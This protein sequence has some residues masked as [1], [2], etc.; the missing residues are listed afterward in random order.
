MPGCSPYRSS[1]DVWLTRRRAELTLARDAIA[2]A[3]PGLARAE[4]AS[5]T[6][7]LSG[8][9]GIAGVPVVAALTVTGRLAEATYAFLGALGVAL[10]LA[11]LGGLVGRLRERE[12]HAL[13]PL[14]APSGDSA[15]DRAALE[16]HEPRATLNARIAKLMSARRASL[17][18]PLVAASLLGP[19]ALH[20]PIAAAFGVPA[21]AFGE[22]IGM[23]TLIVGL[24]H[25]T[26]A[27]LS[28]RYV[29]RLLD[30]QD[31]DARLSFHREWG[32][33]LGMVVVAGCLPGLILLAVPPA[34]VALTGLPLVPAMFFWAEAAAR[35]EA[36]AVGRARVACATTDASPA[37]PAPRPEASHEPL[38]VPT[39]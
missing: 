14:P 32:F 13:P 33:A 15:R 11:V 6:R 34:L 27:G 18:V 20:F 3:L 10:G 12:G 26:L 30:A 7:R 8:A 17:N 9:A 35:D 31:H 16:A 5:F 36:G 39:G 23:S 21:A 38:D 1:D 2:P 37:Q 19:L 24:A 4:V 22:W 28:L 25:L 29:H